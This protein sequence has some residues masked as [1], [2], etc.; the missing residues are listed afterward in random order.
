M[1]RIISYSDDQP[2]PTYRALLR[3]ATDGG[4]D[5]YGDYATGFHADDLVWQA[6]WFKTTIAPNLIGM[7]ALDRE[8][9]YQNLWYGQR[10]NY[11]ARQVIDTVN[12]MFWDLASRHARQPIYKLLGACRD[13]IPAYYDIGGNTID[14]LV[15][16]AV[17][18]KA[19]ATRA[20]RIIHTR[21]VKANIQLAKELRA[22]VGPDFALMHDC[23]WNYTYKNAVKVGRE[24]ERQNYAWM[25]EPLMDYGTC[26]HQEAERHAGPPDS[27]PRVSRPVAG[28]PTVQR[29]GLYM[30]MK[31]VDII[32]QHAVGV[33]RQLKLAHLAES[34]GIPRPRPPGARSSWPSATTPSSRPG[35]GASRRRKPSWMCEE[36]SS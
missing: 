17:R 35:A 8:A 22:A 12:D 10:F 9:I 29:V 13:R 36:A 25:E 3:L 32:R 4:I 19:S 18:V 28:Q 14:E 5:A 6:Q 20:R 31:A 16:D 11:T 1:D 26:W 30:A 27:G 7:D 33:T 34:F 24:L 2:S 15:A 21:G 23:V